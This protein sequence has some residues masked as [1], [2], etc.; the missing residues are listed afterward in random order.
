M[1]IHVDFA[2]QIYFFLVI[3]SAGISILLVKKA[4]MGKL[5]MF[6]GLFMSL[7]PPF[8][9]ILVMLYIANSNKKLVK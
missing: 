8:S 6:I 5:E 2:A 9:F 3:V 7:L 1:N 4:K